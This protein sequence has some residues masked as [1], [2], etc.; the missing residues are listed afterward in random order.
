M[1]E[2]PTDTRGIF[3]YVGLGVG[4]MMPMNPLVQ[5]PLRQ[6]LQDSI[7]GAYA[8]QGFSLVK[9]DEDTVAIY[10]GDILGELAVLTRPIIPQQVRAICQRQLARQQETK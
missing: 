3:D 5:H 7:L 1:S 8:Q 2:Q 6:P 10:L 4:L 9:L